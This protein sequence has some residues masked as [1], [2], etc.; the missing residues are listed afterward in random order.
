MV[1][2]Q[3]AAEHLRQQLEIHHGNIVHT[4][5]AMGLTRATLYGSS[6]VAGAEPIAKVLES[7]ETMRREHRK[8]Q[9]NEGPGESS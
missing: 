5:K 1:D 7:A 9:A 8:A 2:P 6:K 4:A 3:G